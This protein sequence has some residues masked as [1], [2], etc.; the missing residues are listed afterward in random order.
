[1]RSQARKQ[2]G[3]T[4]LDHMQAFGMGYI[5]T[6]M[7]NLITPDGVLWRSGDPLLPGRV[8]S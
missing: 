1:M 6:I 4:L 5:E 7:A 3:E 8:C 2:T